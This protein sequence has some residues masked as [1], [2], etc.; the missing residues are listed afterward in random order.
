[1]DQPEVTARKAVYC[2]ELVQ[3]M[4]DVYSELN[5]EHKST[6]GGT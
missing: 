2:M 5:F 4:E 1:M 6:P 3:F